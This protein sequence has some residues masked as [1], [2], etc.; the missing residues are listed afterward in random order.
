MTSLGICEAVSCGVCMDMA[1][2]GIFDVCYSRHKHP[3][4]S[5]VLRRGGFSWNT[6]TAWRAPCDRRSPSR[7]SLPQTLLTR[8][9][10]SRGDR[11]R[12]GTS[13]TA[14]YSPLVTGEQEDRAEAPHY[15]PVTEALR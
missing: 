14:Q 10:N 12:T 11:Y 9:S 5:Q 8:Q 1:S 6:P 7:S 4:G 15:L 13:L 2:L 3:E